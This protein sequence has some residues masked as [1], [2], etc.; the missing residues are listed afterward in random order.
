MFFCAHW[1]IGFGVGAVEVKRKVFFL[2]VEG[3]QPLG[4]YR[5]DKLLVLQLPVE[6]EDPV[7]VHSQTSAV[8]NDD[9]KLLQLP[10]SKGLKIT[11]TH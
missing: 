1:E 4:P 3:A 6:I 2:A 5:R 8:I 7:Q 10:H 11:S 9:A